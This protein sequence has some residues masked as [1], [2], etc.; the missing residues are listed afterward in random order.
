MEG[1]SLYRFKTES[2]EDEQTSRH[3]PSLE[4]RLRKLNTL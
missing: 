2:N 3:V 1:A 4:L